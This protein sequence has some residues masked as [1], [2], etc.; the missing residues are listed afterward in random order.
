MVSPND[1]LVWLTAAYSLATPIIA[2]VYWRSYGPANFL[3]LSDV[4]LAFTL[5]SLLSREPLLAAR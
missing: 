3:W 2:A 5:L 4:A 1:L